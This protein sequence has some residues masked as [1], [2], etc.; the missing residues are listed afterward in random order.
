MDKTS[1]A[2]IVAAIRSLR[3]RVEWKPGRGIR[4]LEKRKRRGQLLPE[5]TLEDYH[6]LI[7]AVL[8]D[9]Q[10]LIYR[11][12]VAGETYG[13]VR[14]VH[15]TQVWIVIFSL[16]GVME[17]AFPPKRPER[18]IARRNFTLLGRIGGVLK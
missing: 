11:Y 15:K 4:H 5:S 12:D 2:D 7:V 10:S 14:G 9:N 16:D 1:S 3:A 6:D 18:Y 13:A 8:S 17:T